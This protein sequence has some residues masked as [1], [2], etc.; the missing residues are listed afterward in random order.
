MD[1]RAL[2]LMPGA[3]VLAAVV[4]VPTAHARPRPPA[5]PPGGYIFSDDFDGPSGS[6]PDASKWMVAKARETI[7]DPT[8]WELPEKE[9]E[10]A[11]ASKD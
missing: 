5:A 2:L 1:R 7:K 6:A 11:G 4:P 9:A 8:R 10:L 3:G